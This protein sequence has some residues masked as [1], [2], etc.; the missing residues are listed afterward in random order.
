MS[1]LLY[2]PAFLVV[3][4]KQRGLATT[5][6]LCVVILSVQ[7]LLAYPFLHEHPLPYLKNAYDFGRIFLYKWTVNWRFLSENTFLDPNFARALLVGHASVLIAFGLFRWCRAAGGPITI[8]NRAV[9]YPSYPGS[10][11]PVTADG[12]HRG[13]F[14]LFDHFKCFCRNHHNRIN[15]QPYRNTVRTFIALPIL[16]MV[17]LSSAPVGV[18]DKLPSRSQV[19]VMFAKFEQF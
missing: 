7:A 10:P 2:L 12:T 15:V 14:R 1:V 5:I 18:E 9:R 19:C 6:R 17:C 13:V 4:V 11:V 3:L 16:F 8:L